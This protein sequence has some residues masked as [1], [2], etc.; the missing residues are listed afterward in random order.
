MPSDS[1]YAQRQFRAQKAGLAEKEMLEQELRTLRR[2]VEALE[3]KVAGLSSEL[4]ARKA[5]AENPR[6]FS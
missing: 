5:P 2:K 3:K 4:A 6:G 1:E